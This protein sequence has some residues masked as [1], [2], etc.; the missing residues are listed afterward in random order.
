MFLGV[1]DPAVA[2]AERVDRAAIPLSQ[3]FGHVTAFQVGGAHRL[4]GGSPGDQLAGRSGSVGSEPL[5]GCRGNARRAIDD[6]EP[7]M[8]EI[9][10]LVHRLGDREAKDAI[11]GLQL[12][13]R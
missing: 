4:D 8:I 9:G 12:I 7:Q 11:C 1:A 6:V 3:G 10:D 13:G 5:V 2:L